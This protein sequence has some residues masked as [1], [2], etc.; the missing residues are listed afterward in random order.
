MGTLAVA[1]AATATA[2]YMEANSHRNSLGYY[3]STG[4]AYA[5][6]GDTMAFATGASVA[7]MLKRFK[8]T[9]ATK[10]SRFVL[11]KMDEGVGLVKLNKDTGTKEKEIILRDK[12]PEYQVDEF[13]G[14]LYYKAS[15]S[16]IYAYDLKK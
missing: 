13:G 15:S 16:S 4:E 1:A 6:M 7:E 2:S 3:T 8:A 12:K 10:N 11:T 9:S 5:D 14:V